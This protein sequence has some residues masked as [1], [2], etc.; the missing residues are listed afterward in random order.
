M[1]TSMVTGYLVSRNIRANFSEGSR[2]HPGRMGSCFFIM[3]DTP[4][5]TIFGGAQL[6]A[7]PKNTNW[8]AGL[9]IVE[10]I[11]SNSLEIREEMTSFLALAISGLDWQINRMK[12]NAPWRVG[13]ANGEHYEIRSR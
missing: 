5:K 4:V 11:Q 3:A 10:I 8:K 1:D 6:Q 13:S 9:K 12:N 2:R 7:M